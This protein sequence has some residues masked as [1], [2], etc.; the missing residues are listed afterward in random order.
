MAGFFIGGSC[1]TLQVYDGEGG[2]GSTFRSGTVQFFKCPTRCAAQ[3][4]VSGFSPFLKQRR[5]PA[6]AAVA[7]GDGCVAKQ[8]VETSAAHWGAV[9]V[10]LEFGRSEEHT[11][12]LQ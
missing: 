1:S 2:V 11:S 6:H 7:H 12:E 10:A 8:S 5:E 3:A 4:F 9:E